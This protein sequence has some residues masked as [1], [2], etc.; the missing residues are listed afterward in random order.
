[1]RLDLHNIARA[2]GGEVQGHQALV[3]GPGHGPRDRSLSIR[4]SHQSPDGF[5]VFSHAGD[6]WTTP[7]RGHRNLPFRPPTGVAAGLGCLLSYD[8]LAV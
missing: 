7:R 8:D 5:V 3:P 6:Y 1:M 2:L 4:L